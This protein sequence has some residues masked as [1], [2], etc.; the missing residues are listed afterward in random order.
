MS[1][2]LFEQH[3]SD[4]NFSPLDER[5]KSGVL[6]TDNFENIDS[7]LAAPDILFALETAKNK[8]Q[9][10]AVYFRHFQDGRGHVPQLYIYMIIPIKSFPMKVRTIYIS[11]CGMDIRFQRI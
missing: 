4:L 3:I 5:K 1:R 10:D 9:A 6:L 8:F 7:E 2:L 11:K